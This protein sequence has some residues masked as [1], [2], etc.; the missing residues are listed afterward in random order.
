[1]TTEEQL[2]YERGVNGCLVNRLL[3]VY[4]AQG[5]NV[6]EAARK[7]AEDADFANLE[8]RMREFPIVKNL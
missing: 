3:D 2:K 4:M 8:A 6:H 7:A 5:M 1:M